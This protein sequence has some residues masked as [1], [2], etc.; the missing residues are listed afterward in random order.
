MSHHHV[1]RHRW[2]NGTLNTYTTSFKTFEE[3]QAFAQKAQGDSIKIYNE[4]GE[5]V[6]EVATTSQNT[7]A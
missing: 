7:Y 4:D 6:H 1:K 3:A 5:C 2:I